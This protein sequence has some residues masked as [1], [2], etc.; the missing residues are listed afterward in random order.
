MFVVCGKPVLE[1]P[2]PSEGIYTPGDYEVEVTG[3]GGEFKVIVSFDENSI[4]KIEIPEHNETADI[5]G[6]VIE[7]FPKK[8]VDEQTLNIDAI[9]GATVTSEA[10]LE[11]VEKAV[12]KAGGD[13][14]A[15]KAKKA[16]TG[17]VE[18]IEETVDVIV[19]GGG[20]AGLSAAIA[21][22]QEGA[23]VI[24]IEKT[25]VLG[26]NT[27]RA[28][29]PYNAVDPERQKAVEAADETAMEKN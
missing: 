19:I 6:R 12:E 4:T 28:G 16:E 24:L 7:D 26:G 17:E 10:V 23:T 13:P 11:A 1:K 22:A 3:Y 14:A 25:G 8:I 21:A 9:V 20:G 15:L 18:T 2:Q 5:G 29:G 27:I